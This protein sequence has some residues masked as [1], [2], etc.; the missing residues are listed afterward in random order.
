[1][2]L[3]DNFDVFANRI[4]SIDIEDSPKF[5]RLNVKQMICHC[6]DQFKMLFGEVEGLERQNVDLIK[7]RE[8]TIKNETLPTVKGLDQLA[9]EGTKPT[10]FNNDKEELLKYL[11]KFHNCD[12]NSEFHFHPYF[13]EI[14]ADRW[15][16]LVIHHLD[17]HLKQFGR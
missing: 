3:K 11:T 16:K 1:M 13:G 10:D 9:G 5:G 7:L 15:D 14:N 2:L 4:N 8:M 6:T 17:H 12:Y